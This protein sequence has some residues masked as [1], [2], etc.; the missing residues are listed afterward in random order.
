MDELMFLP[1]KLEPHTW[2]KTI[3]QRSVQWR[4][5]K[6]MLGGARLKDKIGNKKL[7]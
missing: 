4:S 7:I 5:Q 1:L 3:Y 2:D 6:F